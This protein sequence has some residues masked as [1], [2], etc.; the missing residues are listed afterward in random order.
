M[1][2]SEVRGRERRRYS[3]YSTDAEIRYIKSVQVA[4]LRE[5]SCFAA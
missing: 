3:T 1:V 5:G 4:G 2:E